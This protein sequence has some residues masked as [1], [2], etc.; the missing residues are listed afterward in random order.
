MNYSPMASDP[1]GSYLDANSGWLFDPSNNNPFRQA[2]DPTGNLSMN[3]LENDPLAQQAAAAARQH[4][5]MNGLPDPYGQ[6]MAGQ[7]GKGLGQAYQ[8]ASA[9]GTP[10]WS[11]GNTSGS[12]AGYSSGPMQGGNLGLG[13]AAGA[14][15]GASMG[16][17]MNSPG[18]QM[19][20]GDYM[21]SPY[22]SQNP[23]LEGA[24]G[25]I[26]NRVTGNLQRNILPQ[27]S[28][29]AA[30]GGAYGGSRQGVLE[31]NA[32]RDANLGLG[33]SL[34]G[35]YSNDWNSQQNR[36]LSRYQGDQGF[37]TQQRGQDQTGA[38]LGAN[39][40]GQGQQGQWNALNNASGVYN[41][42]SGIGNSNTTQN[43]GGGASG[44][45]GGTLG[46]YVLGKNIWGGTGGSGGSWF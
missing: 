18:A 37:Y 31:A 27:I 5:T 43:T 10:G 2:A 20:G 40:Y 35:M 26:T 41:Q 1:Q 22:G 30:E 38:V 29:Y 13:A 45:L 9:G 46:G 33:D 8:G 24:A 28:Q 7:M 39:L 16:A 44:A 3:G 34:A 14:A 19:Q 42:Y 11:N 17:P 4:A 15:G 23:Y 32:M 36:N 21:G 12:A 25:A 6:Q